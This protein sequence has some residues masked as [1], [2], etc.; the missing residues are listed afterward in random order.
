MR[1]SFY[2][3]YYSSFIAIENTQILVLILKK[4]SFL[5]FNH[6]KLKRFNKTKEKPLKVL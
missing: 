5:T 4:V 1:K 2:E 3:H 6:S